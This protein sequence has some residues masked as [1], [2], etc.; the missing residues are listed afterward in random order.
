MGIYA[1]K[2]EGE[3]FIQIEPGTYVARC[4]SMI[5]IGTIEIEFN[6]KKKKQKKVM[7]T[8]ELPTETAI[9]NEDKGPEPFAVSKTYT[10]SMHEKSSLRKDLESWRGKGFTEEQT[11]RFDITKVLGQPCI[12]SIIH[13]PSK[14]DPKKNFTKVSSISKLMKGQECPAQIN[15][16]RLLCYENFDWDV[17]DKLSDYTKDKIKNSDEFQR[18]QEPEVVRET[19]IG[20]DELSDL[21]F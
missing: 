5:E 15:P 12:L 13:E 2:K 8:W 10:L 7:I 20:N 6:G 16:E 9:F 4:F 17:Y 19:S 11:R 21:P 18:M 1:E 3:D 14:T